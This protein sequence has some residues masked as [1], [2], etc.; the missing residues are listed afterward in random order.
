MK[1]EKAVSRISCNKLRKSLVTRCLRDHNFLT[2]LM[3]Q[4]V[5]LELCQ[6]GSNV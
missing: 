6:Y 1:R 2:A 5:T 4:N 3:R